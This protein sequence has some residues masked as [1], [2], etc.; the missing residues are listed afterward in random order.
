MT[1]R[2]RSKKF[3]QLGIRVLRFWKQILACVALQS[4]VLFVLL[5]APFE[6][7]EPSVKNSDFKFASC[8]TTKGEFKVKFFPDLA[9]NGTAFFRTSVSKHGIHRLR[10]LTRL[11]ID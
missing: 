2:V 9:P 7:F 5:S 10:Y 8:L 1:N 3:R 11:L 6:L 4:V